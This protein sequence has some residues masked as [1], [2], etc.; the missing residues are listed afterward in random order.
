MTQSISTPLDG[1]SLNSSHEQQLLISPIKDET[2]MAPIQLGQTVSNNTVP[3]NSPDV[4][5]PAATAN[6]VQQLFTPS[7]ASNTQQPIIPSPPA[8]SQQ[9]FTP[10]LGTNSQQYSTNGPATVPTC[11][12]PNSQSNGIEQ[13]NASIIDFGGDKWNA[14]GVP[15]D[16]LNSIF[17]SLVYDEVGNR[18][19]M[20][21][22][23]SDFKTIFVFVRSLLCFTAKE[24]VEDLA[25]I[26][27]NTLTN[28]QVRLVVITPSHWKHLRNFRKLT[29]YQYLIFSD[30]DQSIYN[31]LGF[32]KVNDLGGNG[33]SPHVKSG[34][35]GGIFSSMRRAL[36][37][38]D[39][40][41]PRDQQGGSMIVGPGPYLHFSHVD[42]NARDHYSINGLL[43]K[44]GVQAIN[45]PHQYND[46]KYF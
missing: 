21:T 38:S 6:G 39:S 41:G 18:H 46:S 10:T 3:P 26:P 29:R 34:N 27:R 14:N 43:N 44:V 8:N 19:E 1:S 15:Q 24:Y 20:H 40:Q 33:D 31:K 17:N 23:W 30:M 7:L 2:L 22:L 28:A 5:N 45:F 37:S 16:S 32:N 42:K 36:S 12:V 25:M 35:F 13:T 9:V 4:F 11:F